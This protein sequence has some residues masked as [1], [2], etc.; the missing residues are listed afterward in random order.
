MTVLSAARSAA[1]RLSQVQ[2]DSLFS[3]T[4]PFDVEMADL[5]TETAISIAKEHDW[6]ALTKLAT[7]TGDGVDTSFMLPTDYDR[8]PQKANV[9]SISFSTASF[10][11]ALDLDE[12][13]NLN[14]FQSN[15]SP[16]NWIILAGEM[17]IFPAMPVGETARFYY[18]SKNIVA[19]QTAFLADDNEFV[20]PE[21]LL[22]L[23][24][25]WRWR[26]MKRTEYAE[27]LRNYEI[28][29]SQEIKND[30][31]AQMITVGRQR[32]P[33]G[34]SVAYPGIITP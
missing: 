6:Q 8:M 11:R 17:Q 25:I 3:S 2:P 30:K 19:N 21:R 13:L 1:I 9:H 20:L 32:M 22:T 33:A 12:W 5:A 18:I 14:D 26:A 29:L 15:G 16:G 4:Q 24:L 34:I 23:G 28:A 7:L 10:R 31:G 27:D